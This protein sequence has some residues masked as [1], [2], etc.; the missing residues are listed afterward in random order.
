MIGATDLADRAARLEHA[1]RVG[2]PVVGD[3]LGATQAALHE[4]IDGLTERRASG[5]PEA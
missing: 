3:L 1:M 5:W 4:V 2:H